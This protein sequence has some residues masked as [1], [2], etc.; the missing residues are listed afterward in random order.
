MQPLHVA[1]TRMHLSNFKLRRSPDGPAC[2]HFLLLRN[3][4]AVPR[5]AERICERVYVR[6]LGACSRRCHL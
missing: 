3:D 2:V 1:W 5:I 6:A 4:G